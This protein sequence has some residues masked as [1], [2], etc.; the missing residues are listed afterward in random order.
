MLFLPLSAS[1]VSRLTY[2]VEA[3][4]AL[5]CA[6]WSC[7]A[8][9]SSLHNTPTINCTLFNVPWQYN[10]IFVPFWA[11]KIASPYVYNPT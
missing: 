1:P 2:T 3:K 11:V 10:P 4:S 5:L 7:P 6:F 9:I 8:V